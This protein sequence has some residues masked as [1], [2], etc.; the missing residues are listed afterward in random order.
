[1]VSN[2]TPLDPVRAQ[3]ATASVKEAGPS[4]KVARRP[5]PRP[6]I[7]APV[8]LHRVAVRGGRR[9]A[10]RPELD[11]AVGVSGHGDRL[12]LPAAGSFQ[13]EP[14]LAPPCGQAGDDRRLAGRQP[15]GPH[16]LDPVDR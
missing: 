6:V 2:T 9:E 5:R 1:M 13:E 8:D 10:V 4:G 7:R 15:S 3:P 11:D 12:Q 16:P 14:G